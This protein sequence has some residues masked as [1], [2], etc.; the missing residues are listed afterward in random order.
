MLKGV[1]NVPQCAIY[2]VG[3]EKKRNI[4]KQYFVIMLKLLFPVAA[5]IILHAAVR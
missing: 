4:K 1:H 2:D 3:S 5:Y